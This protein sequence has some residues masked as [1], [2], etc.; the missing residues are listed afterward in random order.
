MVGARPDVEVVYPVSE[1][2]RRHGAS[3]ERETRSADEAYAASPD[4][5]RR[6]LERLGLPWRR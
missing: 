5:E 2:A 3:V 6:R 4:S 1:L